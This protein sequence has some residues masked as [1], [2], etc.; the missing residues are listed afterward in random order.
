MTRNVWCLCC[1]TYCRPAWWA[2]MSSMDVCM[3]GWSCIHAWHQLLHVAW[4][5]L[6]VSNS[7]FQTSL[8][9]FSDV[10]NCELEAFTIWFINKTQ[11][12][13]TVQHI[14]IFTVFVEVSPCV[15]HSEVLWS[16]DFNNIRHLNPVVEG[17]WVPSIEICVGHVSDIYVFFGYHQDTPTP[18]GVQESSTE[19]HHMIESIW[20]TCATTKWWFYIPCFNLASWYVFMLVTVYVK[21]KSCLLLV[22]TYTRPNSL[23]K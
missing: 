22:A 4:S 12:H 18:C 16:T 11:S 1:P 21:V 2:M 20:T 7:M 14:N 23:F 6:S 10:H 8:L 15:I 3:L 5:S 9:K 13:G 17:A 19:W